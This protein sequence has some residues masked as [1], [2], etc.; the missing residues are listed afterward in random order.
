MNTNTAKDILSRA[1][2]LMELAATFEAR[3]NA[4][5][6]MRPGSPNDAWR[7]H[8]DI[9]DAQIEIARLLN[10][11][12]LENPSPVHGMWWE[13]HDVI[14][15]A[16]VREMITQAGRLVASCA[17]QQVNTP[18]AD[19]SYATISIEHTISGLLMHTARMVA[20]DDAMRRVAG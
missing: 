2:H 16:A 19:W 20:A 13:H 15:T 1:A 6:V 5:Y 7:L 8:D 12:V 4:N 18:D 9:R 3:Y 11:V 17:Y 10:P 14:D